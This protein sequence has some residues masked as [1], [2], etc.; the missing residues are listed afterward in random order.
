MKSSLPYLTYLVL[1]IFVILCAQYTQIAATYVVDFYNHIDT[2][3][4][5]F[6]SYTPSGL[7]LR[8]IV[9]LVIGPLIV[10]GIPA[11]IYRM[12]KHT[13]MPHF[14]EI[15]WLVWITIVLSNLL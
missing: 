10:T 13:P 2:S 14:I 1:S 9:A 6:F 5:I 3:I 15:T 4:A 11:L 8:H 12:V 7:A